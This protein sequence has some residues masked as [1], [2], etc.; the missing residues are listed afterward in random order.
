MEWNILHPGHYKL[1]T[2]CKASEAETSSPSS[3]I[4]ERHLLCKA[5]ISS[6]K[7]F[8]TLERRKRKVR[9]GAFVY[10]YGS[11]YYLVNVYFVAALDNIDSMSNVFCSHNKQ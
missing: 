10:L 5:L 8:L 6:A 4:H 2:V 11:S 1:F 9:E 3:L 7:C